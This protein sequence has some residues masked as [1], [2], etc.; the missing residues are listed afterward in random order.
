MNDHYQAH[1]TQINVTHAIFYASRSKI[2]PR[3]LHAQHYLTTITF[4]PWIPETIL[5]LNTQVRGDGSHIQINS[6]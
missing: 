4:V 2:N 1:T 6:N 3:L 5:F